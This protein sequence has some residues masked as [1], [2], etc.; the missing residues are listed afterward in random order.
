[1]LFIQVVLGLGDYLKVVCHACVGGTDVREDID[2]LKK[3]VHV[4]VG[5]P[6]R[7]FDM[8]G[9]R[10]C[11][12]VDSI[13]LFVLDEADEML[14][15]GFKSQIYDSTLRCR[16]LLSQDRWPPPLLASYEL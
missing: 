15:R 11:V 14:S 16:V 6:G 9:N 3:G 12:H 13:K 2:H 7:V 10:R 4:I 8:M 1:M 5:T